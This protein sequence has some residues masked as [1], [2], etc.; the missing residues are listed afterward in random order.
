MET[1]V[2]RLVTGVLLLGIVAAELAAPALMKRFK[3]RTLLVL[4]RR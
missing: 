2:A 3:Y 4:G 1:R